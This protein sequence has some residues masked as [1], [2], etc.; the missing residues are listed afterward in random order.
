MI[1]GIEYDERIY[2]SNWVINW[3]LLYKISCFRVLLEVASIKMELEHI[4]CFDG[5]N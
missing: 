5:T 3:D 1:E 2:P 4:F